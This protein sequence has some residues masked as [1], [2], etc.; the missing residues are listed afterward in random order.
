MS[1]FFRSKAATVILFGSLAVVLFATVK[2][3]TQKYQVD[4][5]IAELQAR[6]DRVRGENQ[7][8]SELV[9]Y[10]NTTQYQ[11][12][13]AREKLNLKKEGEFVVSLPNKNEN[14]TEYV[15]PTPESNPKKWYNFFF[16][17]S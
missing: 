10:L 11:Q 12:K 2:L 5:Q 6:A 1:K 7:K 15:P 3:L 9:N 17:N 4:K 13:E 16:K 8:L 14:T